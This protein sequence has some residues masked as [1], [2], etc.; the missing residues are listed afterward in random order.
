MSSD[1]LIKYGAL[2]LLVV[3]NAAVA[4]VTSYSR[5]MDGPKFFSTTAGKD[6]FQL[7][8]ITDLLFNFTFDL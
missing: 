6:I 5:T 3:Q 4:L 2:A 8:N 7:H 1:Y